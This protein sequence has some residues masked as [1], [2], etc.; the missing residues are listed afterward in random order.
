MLIY[1]ANQKS[2]NSP[3]AA[4]MEAYLKGVYDAAEFKEEDH[5]RGGKGSEAG[6]RF[7]KSEKTKRKE[8]EVDDIGEI[9]KVDEELLG[10]CDKKLS[11]EEVIQLKKIASS[12]KSPDIL[13]KLA[14]AERYT[15][16]NANCEIQ[17][18]VANNPHTP[19]DI[20][21]H[22]SGFPWQNE[23]HHGKVYRNDV[24]RSAKSTLEGLK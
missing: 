17:E 19:K 2:K 5:P 3:E 23:D 10:R 9:D 4:A 21:K 13:K 14:F 1:D 22:L 12:T 6:G 16:S 7:V 11:E 18:A 8:D 24:A 20:L 15:S